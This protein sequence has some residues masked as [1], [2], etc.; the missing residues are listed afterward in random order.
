MT[1]PIPLRASRA[2]ASCIAEAGDSA[3]RDVSSADVASNDVTRQADASLPDGS[4]G[5]SVCDALGAEFD[6][7]GGV[8]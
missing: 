5:L 7:F 2:T 4:I 8:P 6:D 1:S 3:G